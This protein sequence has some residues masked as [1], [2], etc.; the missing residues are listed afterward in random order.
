MWEPFEAGGTIGQE[1][2]ENG[3]IIRDEKHLWGARI[4]LE[5]STPTAPFAITC[6]VYRWMVHTRFFSTEAEAGSQFDAMKAALTEII[7]TRPADDGPDANAKM[8]GISEAL[9]LFIQRHP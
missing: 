6:G 9:T 7:A 3:T 4:T 5:R 2:S 1:G 8:D